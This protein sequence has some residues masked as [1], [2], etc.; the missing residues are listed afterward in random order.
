MICIVDYGMGNLRSV[1]KA[2]DRVGAT[3]VVSPNARDI[4]RAEAL[5]LPGVG[6]FGDAMRNLRANGLVQ[7][8]L[9]VVDAGKPVLGICLGMQLLFEESEELGIHRG[10]GLLPGRVR[11]FPF[12][13]RA[14][15]TLGP[16]RPMS[17]VPHIGWNQI[18]IRRA[19]PLL[20]GV[21]DGS[22]AYFV[23][24]YYVEPGHPSPVVAETDYGLDFASVVGRGN[25]MGIQFH[26][27]KSQ[28]VGL[29]ILANFARAIPQPSA[30]DCGERSSGPTRSSSAAR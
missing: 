25:R 21:P 17:K 10:L 2:F 19:H 8:L 29:R 22:F 28:A 23:H 9:A 18:R 11:R 15:S 3:A 6:A 7:P 24:S 26:P 20:E 14:A 27:E 5:V 12:G 30:G 13:S 16:S 1:Q 4:E